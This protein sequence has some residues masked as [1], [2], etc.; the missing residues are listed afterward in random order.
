MCVEGGI[1]YGALF[2]F[3]PENELPL[4][5]LLLFSSPFTLELMLLVSRL[6]LLQNIKIK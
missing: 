3:F 5:L 6:V 1:M 4:L 2:S